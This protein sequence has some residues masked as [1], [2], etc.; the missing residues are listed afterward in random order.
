MDIF[1][2]V[3]RSQEPF[4]RRYAVQYG[5]PPGE[6]TPAMA[7]QK[8]S[9]NRQRFLAA[10][11][12]GLGAGVQPEG[13]LGNFSR[14]FAGSI[15]G[16]MQAA[17]MQHEQ[18]RQAVQDEAAKQ[19]AQRDYERDISRDANDF[20]RLLLERRRVALEGQRED[21]LSK[22]QPETP[23]S[24]ERDYNALLK[25]GLSSSEALN[26]AFGYPPKPGKDPDLASFG[27]LNTL[28]D[29]FR[30]DP[31]VK[32]YT[33]VRDNYRRIVNQAKLNSGPGDLSVIFAFMRTLDPQSVVRESEFKNAEQAMGFL[34]RM[35]NV[36]TKFVKG[37]RLTP[38]GRAY[39]V[40]AAKDLY[41]TQKATY[42]N[43]VKMYRKQAKAYNVD[44]NL[45]IPEY[46]EDKQ[47]AAPDLIYN[48]ATGQLEP[49]R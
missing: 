44:S 14:A 40:R 17:Q 48:P 24:N 37:N 39:F 45:I 23:T 29:N 4:D 22:P 35:Y 18:E 19:K 6:T 27:A 5:N 31:N 47:G 25:L 41:G 43:I 9:F 8:R 34:N 1:D 36:P 2:T 46:D 30:Q 3:L 28:S 49:A 21:R 38:E 33:V 20:D 12:G 10:L 7:A 42:D 13:F 26:R 32:N 11:A 16:G 15:G